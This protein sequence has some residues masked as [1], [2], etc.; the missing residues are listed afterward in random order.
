MTMNLL[1]IIDAAFIGLIAGWASWLSLQGGVPWGFGGEFLQTTLT[2]GLLGAILLGGEQ[3]VTALWHEGRMRKAG[4]RFLAAAAVGLA[5][6]MVAAVLFALLGEWAGLARRSPEILLRLLWWA[7]FSVALAVSRGI[8]MNA[9]KAA[10]QSFMGLAP[11][12]ILAGLTADMVLFP[13]GVWVG[14][15]LLIGTGASLGAALAAELLKESWIEES[16]ASGW[17]VQYRLETEE[18]LVGSD[19]G[20]DLSLDEGPAQWFVITE[21]DGVHILECLDETP[22]SFIGGRYRYRPLVDGDVMRLGERNFIYRSRYS[23]SRDAL[24]ETVDG[25]G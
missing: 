2:V 10:C 23:R 21:H 17:P 1:P 3:A 18:L 6:S 24:A 12:L 11:A 20:C 5:V 4:Q 22:V 8:V 15:C 19:E 7:V 9:P 16:V 25:V 14:G 13:R